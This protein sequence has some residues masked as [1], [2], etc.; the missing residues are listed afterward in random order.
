M[1]VTRIEQAAEA[2][3]KAM[4]TDADFGVLLRLVAAEIDDQE[5]SNCERYISDAAARAQLEESADA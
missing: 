4:L 2:F 5:N 3:G 1:A